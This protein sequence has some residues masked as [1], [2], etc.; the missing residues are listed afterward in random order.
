MI[1][2]DV[3]ATGVNPQKHS[4]LSIGAID[5]ENPKRQFSGECRIFEGAHVSD[6]GLAVNG[7]TRA[8]I[9]DTTKQTDKE[10]VEKFLEWAM[11]SSDHTIGG[12]NPSFDRDFIEYTALRYH[13]NWPLTKRTVDMH[14]VCYLH[15][16]QRKILP[17]IENNRS[18]LNSDA[19]MAYVGIP[20]E[21]KP[22][23]ALN[24]ARYEAEAFSR[25]LHNRGILAEF[26]KFP[27]P[28]LQK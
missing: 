24:G 21:P 8:Q 13:L 28:W 16:I 9:E 27:I 22:H 2:V 12:Q 10:L 26:E 17:P 3:E 19:I 1:I 6:E 15:M 18:N 14:S 7:F 4:L 23:I 20:V 5:F 11:E 25:L